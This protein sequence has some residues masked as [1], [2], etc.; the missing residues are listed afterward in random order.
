MYIE[1][2]S[3]NSHLCILH[4][5]EL[6]SYKARQAAYPSLLYIKRRRRYWIKWSLLYLHHTDQM[7]GVLQYRMSACMFQRMNAVCMH[8]C[9]ILTVS[10]L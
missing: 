3:L 7:E 8:R 5:L 9:A 6:S 10:Y 2:V 4:R 1:S